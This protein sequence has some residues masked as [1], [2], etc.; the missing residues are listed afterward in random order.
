MLDSDNQ[1]IERYLS[2]DQ[3]KM[4]I[5]NNVIKMQSP[6]L[7]GQIQPA[8]LDLRL[9]SRAWRI[10]TSFLPGANAG[11]SDKLAN[12]ALHEIDLTDGAVL[13]KGCVY[14]VELQESLA[15][16]SHL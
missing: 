10:Q 14:L 16:P 7:D 5:A 9:S 3:I 2:S 6:P 1:P 12:L 8:S 11:V 4:A 13:E 15:L